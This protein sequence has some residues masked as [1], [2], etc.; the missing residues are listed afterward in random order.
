MISLEKNEI[1]IQNIPTIWI[2]LVYFSK[3]KKNIYI[4]IVLV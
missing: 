4:Y 1:Y 2:L 3:K